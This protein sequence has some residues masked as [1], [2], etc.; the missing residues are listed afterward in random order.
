MEAKVSNFLFKLDKAA[1]VIE[2]FDG[3]EADRPVGLIRV[4]VDITEKD[5]HTELSYWM[6]EN[7]HQF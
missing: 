2:V 1:N 7:G 6:M 3:S 5:F 4:K